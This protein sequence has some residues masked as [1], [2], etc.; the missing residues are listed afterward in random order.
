MV[1]SSF[2]AVHET[3]QTKQL[4][5]KFLALVD[6]FVYILLFKTQI[7]LLT[8]YNRLLEYEPYQQNEQETNNYAR[9]TKLIVEEGTKRIREKFLNSIIDG[10]TLP[11]ILDRWRNKMENFRRDGHLKE[12]QFQKLYPYDSNEPKLDD[13]DLTLWLFLARNLSQRKRKVNWAKEP[14]END[15]LWQHNALRLRFLRN[16]IF[17]LPQAQLQDDI[18]QQYWNEAAVILKNLNSTDDIIR[19]YADCNMD[20]LQ[21]KTWI[22]R[23]R[24][25]V[26]DEL[27]GIALR[28]AKKSRQNR[29]MTAI[30]GIVAV[31]L[32]NSIVIPLAYFWRCQTSCAKEL[33]GI[34]TG[35][36]SHIDL[37][38]IIY[39]RPPYFKLATQ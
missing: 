14:G 2:N 38:Y 24:E 39:I 13:I 15:K 25:S 27:H 9:L 1:G 36:M 32:C 20:H 21:T 29:L 31:L 6:L 8:M 11:E 5:I 12:H 3:R 34:Q 22:L 17:H 10:L 18:F 16:K 19:T 26:L 4:N 28:D 37:C 23:F 30:F 7:C 33:Q 35:R